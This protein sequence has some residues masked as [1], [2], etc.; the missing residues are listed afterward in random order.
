MTHELRDHLRNI[1]EEAI[2][3][4]EAHLDWLTLHPQRTRSRSADR[5]Y[6]TFARVEQAVA[7]RAL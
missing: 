1:I 3:R 6:T 4:A 7:R 2:E 5:G